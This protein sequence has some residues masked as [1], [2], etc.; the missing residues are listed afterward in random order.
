MFLNIIKNEN[1]EDVEVVGVYS[2][3]ETEALKLNQ[4]FGVAVAK[5]HDEFVGKIDGLIITARHGDNHYKYAKPYLDSNI[6]IFID[7]PITISEKEAVEF[8]NI[9]K[10]NNVP[11][12]GGSMCIYSDLVLEIKEAIAK[13]ELGKVIGGYLRTPLVSNSEHGGFYF[14]AQH[15]VHVCCE[16]F[17]YHPHSVQ[18]L[19][20]DNKITVVIRYDDYDITGLYL[21]NTDNWIYSVS[22]AFERGFVGGRDLLTNAGSR[23]FH[24]FYDLLKGEK[25]HLSYD[26]LFSPVFIMNAI[27][28][29]L[30]SGNEEK[31]LYAEEI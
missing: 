22:A 20:C 8:M 26:E 9:L 5:N 6:P 1:I 2:Y 16:L 11:A 29:S 4:K 14:Y 25:Q 10:K 13:G 27:E 17:G 15:L 18:T 24:T 19:K 28:R 3:D 12:C 7:K 23:E 30:N 21:D 31:I